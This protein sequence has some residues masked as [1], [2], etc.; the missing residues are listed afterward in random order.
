M[1]AENES[2]PGIS[3]DNPDD[4]LASFSGLIHVRL[5][6]HPDPDTHAIDVRISCSRE[7]DHCYL[8]LAPRHAVDLAFRLVGAV[9]QLT[10]EVVP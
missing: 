9:A 3:G 2:T 8:T 7:G 1:K 6:V 5:G 4:I 10:G